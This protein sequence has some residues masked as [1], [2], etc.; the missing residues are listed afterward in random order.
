[1]NSSNRFNRR[2]GSAQVAAFPAHFSARNSRLSNT[3]PGDRLSTAQNLGSLN[4]SSVQRSGTVGSRDLDFFKF[5]VDRSTPFTAR[6][7]NQSFNEPIAFSLLDR[8]GNVVRYNGNYQFRNVD[9]GATDD[10]SLNLPAGE[11][12]LRLQSANGRNE[13]YS[14]ELSRS[15]GSVVGDLRDIGR[16]NRGATYR[17]Q[18]SVGGSDIDG[19]RFSLDS[20]SRIFSSLFN[21]SNDPIAISILDSSNRVVQTANGRFLFA[22]AESG[23]R[24]DLFA[25][26]LEAGSYLV[27]IQSAQG[28]REPY[29]FGIERSIFSPSEPIVI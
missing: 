17:S 27:R 21:D 28:S 14:L 1:M 11:Y 26:T 15:G 18:G 2:L 3:D 9:A 12:Y 19:Y 20:R 10:L 24:V 29:R 22:N 4:R 6:L 5:R 16:L 8:R 13:G 7:R 23:D 25:P